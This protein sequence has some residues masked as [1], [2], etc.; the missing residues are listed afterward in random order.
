MQFNKEFIKLDEDDRQ[1]V[2]SIL[3]YQDLFNPF[4]RT[5][6][7]Y[8]ICPNTSDT[9]IFYNN[10]LLTKLINCFA[11][12]GINYEEEYLLNLPFTWDHNRPEEEKVL[13]S[14]LYGAYEPFINIH[15]NEDFLNINDQR[16]LNCGKNFTEEFKWFLYTS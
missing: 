3:Y 6:F 8:Y 12:F 2:I 16:I 1:L 11:T 9:I 10:R 7:K 15:H 14:I 5:D 13:I 4:D